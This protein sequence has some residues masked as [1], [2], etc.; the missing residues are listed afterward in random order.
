[1]LDRS[2]NSAS[3]TI[4]S[5]QRAANP[6]TLLQSVTDKT[7]SVSTP[8][9]TPNST[10]IELLKTEPF[11]RI[12][13]YEIHQKLGE[14]GM[15]IVYR[16]FDVNLR[17]NVAIKV[18]RPE[19]SS[20]REARER[21]LREARSA[22]AISHDNVVT[23]HHV[24]D[25]QGTAYLVMP[26]L[27]GMSLESF[28]VKKGL[29][30]IPQT[31][32][33]AREIA[34]GLYAAHQQELIHRD[35]K[36]GNIWLESP[37]GRVKILDFGI[38]KPVGAERR[39]SLTEAGVVMGTPAFMSPEQARG[40][41]VDCRS[42]LY[43]LGAILYRMCTGTTPFA[44]PTVMETL[45][46]LVSESPPPVRELNPAV[47]DALADLIH[48]LLARQPSERPS[49][50]NEVIRQLRQIERAD[51]EKKATGVIAAESA[52]RF[53]GELPIIARDPGFE[54]VDKD[55]LPQTRTGSRRRK[56]K[57]PKPSWTWIVAA[58]C[59]SAVV[60]MALVGYGIV[61]SIEHRQS[62]VPSGEKEPAKSNPPA[63]ATVQDPISAGPEGD[64]NDGPEPRHRPIHPG[65]EPPPP[66]FR[67]PPPGLEPPPPPPRFG[68]PPGKRFAPKD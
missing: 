56:R 5:G 32:R 38:A 58:T 40:H 45:T 62:A 29:P 37:H 22:A 6:R 13:D 68:P 57:R 25:H 47:P 7:P 65:F 59:F 43:S 1:M 8:N 11:Q 18:L 55:T 66:G 54:I 21:F 4:P 10:P 15:G 33:I 44:R 63:T 64:A 20:N 51:H 24:G 35:V 3:P 41:A 12:A 39:T 46:A 2:P 48:R 49:S 9:S 28:L 42:D 26:L 52:L 36:P 31:I 53:S 61:K 17:R 50:A 23:I 27:K 30:T 67:P 34:A 16:G 60:V 14:G 19:Y